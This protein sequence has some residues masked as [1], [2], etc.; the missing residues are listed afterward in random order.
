MLSVI[1]HVDIIEVR[2]STSRSMMPCHAAIAEL[3]AWREWD[4]AALRPLWTHADAALAEAAKGI[5]KWLLL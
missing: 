1:L 5:V 4:R 3:A 2:A